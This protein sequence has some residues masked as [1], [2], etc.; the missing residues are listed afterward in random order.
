ML[1]LALC[2]LLTSEVDYTAHQKKSSIAIH[3][4]ND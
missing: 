1:D 2:K 3:R 4:A